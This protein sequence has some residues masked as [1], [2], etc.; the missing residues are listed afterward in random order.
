MRAASKAGKIF[1]EEGYS[2][3]KIENHA[4]RR[5]WNNASPLRMLDLDQGLLNDRH[6]GPGH[7]LAFVFHCLFVGPEVGTV[8]NHN[9]NRVS[10]T[11]N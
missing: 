10:G 8:L 1:K 9:F 4:R 7:D 3:V 2:C 11:A 5:R 6:L